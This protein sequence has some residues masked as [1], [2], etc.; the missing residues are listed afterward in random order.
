MKLEKTSP[1]SVKHIGAANN[2]VRRIR[3]RWR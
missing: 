1:M 3:S 2:I